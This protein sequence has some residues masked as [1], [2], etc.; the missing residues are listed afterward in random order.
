MVDSGPN[1]KE[2]IGSQRQDHFINLELRRDREVSMRTTYISRSQSRSGSHLSHEKNTKPCNWRSI[3]LRESCATNGEG[4]LPPIL[5][6]LLTMKRMVVIDPDQGLLL[7]S[8][9][10]MMGTTTMSAETRTHLSKAWE[11]MQ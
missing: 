2:S 8:L 6:S 10:H 4:E 1:L 7:V 3:T 9:S 5:T 11:M